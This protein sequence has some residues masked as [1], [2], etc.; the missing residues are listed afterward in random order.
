MKDNWSDMI[1]QQVA[2]NGAARITAEA[3][4]EQVVATQQVAQAT[5]HVAQETA[6][7]A[8]YRKLSYLLER[9]KEEGFEVFFNKL[10]IQEKRKITTY[11][12]LDVSGNVYIADDYGCRFKSFNI[13][14][15]NEFTIETESHFTG[16]RGHFTSQALAIHTLNERGFRDIK[17]IGVNKYK[18]TIDNLEMLQL[19]FEKVFIDFVVHNKKYKLNDDSTMNCSEDDLKSWLN[20]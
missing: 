4:R 8:K 2:A 6:F 11:F 9:G 17:Y 19:I 3:I 7:N 14:D 13:K 15:L 10:T 16:E 20:K 1:S 5:H 18:F 12:S